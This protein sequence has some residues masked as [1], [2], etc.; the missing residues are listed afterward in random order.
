MTEEFCDPR[1][2]GTF[3]KFNFF[4]VSCNMELSFDEFDALNAPS[5][6]SAAATGSDA[7]YSRLLYLVNNTPAIIYASVPSGDFRM[8]Y[9]SSNAQHV[10]G[11]E[12][13]QMIADP[14]FWFNH[15]HPED[16]ASIFSSLA[17]LFSEGYR[18]YE[19]RFLDSSGRYLW[20]HDMLRLIRDE[21]GSP[22]EVVGSL[23]D[24][25]D[26]KKM[27]DDLRRTGKE[28]QVLI[29]KLQD[30]QQQL[31]QAEKMASVGQLA[32]GIA[33]EINNPIGFVNSNM[34]SLQTYVTA[35]FEL[36]EQYDQ[37]INKL[38]LEDDK[39]KLISDMKSKA[40]LDFIKDDTVALVTESL[41]GL[42][43]V[44]DIVQS[45]K[46]FSHVGEAEWQEADIHLGIESTLNIVKNEIKYKATVEKQYGTLPPVQCVIAELNQVFLNLLINA[47]HAI[48]DKGVI[49]IKT[50]T[51]DR[52][53]Q[54]FVCIKITDTG[55]GIE[56][57]NLNRI[58]E[59]FFTT[60]P[61]GSGTGLGLS[62]AYGIINKHN[63]S[64]TAK[65]VV[66]KGT[67]FTIYLPV[68]QSSAQAVQ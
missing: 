7:A 47:A 54:K 33:H 65:S 63:G 12:P 22:I 67:Q 62:L 21:H 51:Q 5:P 38:A 48:Q 9:V 40:D 3:S 57:E 45:L 17:L 66:G 30:A 32:A 31:L 42:K 39:T 4:S 49:A 55:C 23:T 1:R 27:E 11:Y 16:A 19:Y 37:F 50:G 6:A 26:R 60:K 59:P 25:T 41:D 35:M 10:L 68:N 15:I 24:I 53:G 14:N 61:V 20:M 2:D 29:Q 36:L 13:E 18:T 34:H 28:Q 56:P 43:R 64:I 46:D 44:R 58:F 8:T 52:D